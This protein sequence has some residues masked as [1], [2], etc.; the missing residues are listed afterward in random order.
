MTI[1]FVQVPE[2]CR[3]VKTQPVPASKT[4]PTWVLRKQIIAIRP[5]SP[6]VSAIYLA[7][8]K[9]PIYVMGSNDEVLT[10]LFYSYRARDLVCTES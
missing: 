2:V 1:V 7:G 9:K 6:W 3:P 10:G 8:E 5:W 4:Q